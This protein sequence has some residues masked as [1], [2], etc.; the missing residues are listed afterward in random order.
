[1][2]EAKTLRAQRFSECVSD[3]VEPG[4][5]V[6]SYQ[7]LSRSY[8]GFQKTEAYLA[9]WIERFGCKEVLELGAGANPALSSEYV[10]DAGINYTISDLSS[11][12]LAKAGDNFDQLV[13]DVEQPE[14]SQELT[15]RFDCVFSKLMAEHIS[16]A[17]TFHCNVR[18]LLRPGGLSIH[19]FPTLWALPFAANRFLPAFISRLLQQALVPRDHHQHDKF[20]ARYD[21]SR[22]PTKSVVQRLEALGFEV[23]LYEGYFG[24]FY[25]SRKLPLLH[26][27]EMIKSRFLLRRPVP[28][29]CSYATVI[30]RKKS[31]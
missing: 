26:F 4:V 9:P 11:K 6:I 8:P 29:L 24:H 3:S 30:L 16:D 5:G 12:E 2:E 28:Q 31:A 23:L 13:F 22:G 14:V 1:M 25:Y 10:R 27:A 7:L 18:N 20:P 15:E 19:F 21:W 17:Q